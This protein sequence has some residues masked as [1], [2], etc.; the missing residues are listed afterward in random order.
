MEKVSVFKFPKK[1]AMRAKWMRM[2]PRDGLEV[3]DKTAVCEKHF[4]ADCIVRFDSQTR[5]DGSVLT[6]KRDI[7][8]L[9]SDAYPSIFPNTPHSV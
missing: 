5:A 9:T 2:I 6:V 4:V 3:T 8:K 7:P 1:S